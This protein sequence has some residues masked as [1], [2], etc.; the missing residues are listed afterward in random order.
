MLIIYE[1]LQDSYIRKRQEKE[2]LAKI[3]HEYKEE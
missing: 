1:W 3:D 2:R